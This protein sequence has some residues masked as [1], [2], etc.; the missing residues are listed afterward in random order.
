MRE[1]NSVGEWPEWLVFGYLDI[2]GDIPARAGQECAN[3]PALN[4]SHT[5]VCLD[6]SVVRLPW[7]S[8]ILMM[9]G[10]RCTRNEN[11][12]KTSLWKKGWG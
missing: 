4:L 9:K 11:K 12:Y 1:G 10:N 2:S 8:L 7:M 6:F 3:I 5:A